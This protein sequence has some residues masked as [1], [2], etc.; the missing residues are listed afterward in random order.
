MNAPASVTVHSRRR[1][2]RVWRRI[3]EREHET[4][5]GRWVTLTEW[6]T[7]CVVCERQFVETIP[8]VVTA[9]KRPSAFDLIACRRHRGLTEP[10]RRALRR[11]HARG[12]AGG[13]K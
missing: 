13:R 10:E 4:R 1:P 2:P 11:L 8:G 7:P 9:G 12:E 3:G 6:S 5:D